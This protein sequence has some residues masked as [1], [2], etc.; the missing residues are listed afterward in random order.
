MRK[1]MSDRHPLHKLSALLF[2]DMLEMRE[3]M[4]ERVMKKM[5]DESSSTEELLAMMESLLQLN[6]VIDKE[7]KGRMVGL[8]HQELF[9]KEYRER[10][11][12]K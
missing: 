3:K 4:Q 2:Y 12:R 5:E 11:K 9:D 10:V 7:V 8:S 6:E 1:D